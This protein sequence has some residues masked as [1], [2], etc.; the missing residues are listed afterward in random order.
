MVYRGELGR[1]LTKEEV[2]SNFK[3]LADGVSGLN[4]TVNSLKG[5][6]PK[7]FEQMVLD[8]HAMK[9]AFDKLNRTIAGGS[10]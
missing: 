7:Q 10:Q 9:D 1:P 4:A 5:I 3:E 8:F 2:D 6:D